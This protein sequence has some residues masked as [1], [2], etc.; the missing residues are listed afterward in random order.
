[1]VALG[2]WAGIKARQHTTPPGASLAVAN[3]YNSSASAVNA[4]FLIFNIFCVSLLRAIRPALSIP[5]IQYTIFT[6]VG[7][8]YGPQEATEYHSRLFLKELL[9]S[10]LTG[11]AISAGVS[12]LIIP[13][14]SRKVF[15]GETTGFLQSCRGLLRAQLSFIQVLQHSVLFVPARKP[16]SNANTARSEAE[17]NK[18]LST[19]RATSTGILS[20]GAKLREDVMFAK[21]EIAIGHLRETDIHIV[22]GLIRDIMIPI[23]GLS[24]I[25]DISERTHCR[26][27][28]VEPGQTSENGLS[29][30]HDGWEE[31]FQ[32]LASSFET[33][34][35][36]LDESILHT[37][38]LLG[39]APSPKKKVD[40]DIETGAGTPKPGDL[41]FGDYLE[42]RLQDFRKERSS[43]IQLWAEEKGLS[44]AFKNTAQHPTPPANVNET[45]P[46]PAA[47]EILA[48]RRLH[49]VLYMEYLLYSTAK[50]ILAIVRFAESKVADGTMAKRRFIFPAYKTVLKIAKD[51]I[52][53][54]EP[55]PDTQDIDPLGETIL[56]DSFQ[57]PKD[58]EHLPPKNARQAWGDRVRAIP[59]FLGSDAVRF[60][61]RVTIAVMSIGIMAFLKNSHAFFIAQRVVWACIMTAI[62]MSPTA[63]S[64]VFNMLGNTTCTLFGMIG[65]FINWYMVDGKTAGVIVFFFFFL[66]FYF[67]FAAK[68]PRFLVAIVAG[69]LT[70]VLIIG[71]QSSVSDFLQ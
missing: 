39:L 38:V 54:D 68:F 31:L 61:V 70:H 50:A 3:G 58:P 9:Y 46:G 24:T 66:M 15:F 49:I 2:Q 8:V 56:G 19:L 13:V 6:M 16:E 4:I 62:G 48:S 5:G 37:L 30:E 64:A 34:V 20:L 10:F 43:E 14:S 65:A 67:Y 47:R 63:G 23:T 52:N 41:N 33:V 11:Q 1:M 40:G 53:G 7:F 45:N 32:G 42:Q 25:A 35:Q 12:L 17:Y 44:S 29:M 28:S 69:A 18:R 60:G 36:I 55:G 57:A 22:H 51:L 26:L 59:K 21:R 27:G 71:K